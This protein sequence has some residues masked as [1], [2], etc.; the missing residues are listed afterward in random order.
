MGTGISVFAIPAGIDYPTAS[1][2]AVF[3]SFSPGSLIVL[4]NARWSPIILGNGL[5]GK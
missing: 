5:T 1:V 3:L 4:A 2:G